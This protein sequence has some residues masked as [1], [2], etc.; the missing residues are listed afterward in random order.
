MRELIDNKRS[1]GVNTDKRLFKASLF[2]I[3]GLPAWI[4]GILISATSV[5]H[6][7]MYAL[8]IST[9]IGILNYLPGIALIETGSLLQLVGLYYL[10]TFLKSS[11]WD[12][13]VL[14]PLSTV[15]LAGFVGGLVTSMSLALIPLSFL[16]MSIGYIGLG[17]VLLRLYKLTN[18][19]ELYGASIVFP[20]S[21]STLL[22]LSIVGWVLVLSVSARSP[23]TL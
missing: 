9:T 15:V 21:I 1:V 3:A 2:F 13:H 23:R 5:I 20:I 10:W 17:G 11:Y 22:T 19:P 6:I 12:D 4:S 8:R 7:I 18:S 16:F 14:R